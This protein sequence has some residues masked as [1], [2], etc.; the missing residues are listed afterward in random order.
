MRIAVLTISD[1][2]SR[3]LRADTS[4]DAAAAW[5][6]V[7]NELLAGVSAG[8]GADQAREC[9]RAAARRVSNDHA[10]SAIRISLGVSLPCRQQQ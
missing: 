1:A 3:G 10:H 4:G 5:A 9:V 7:D 8:F 2:G 6:I